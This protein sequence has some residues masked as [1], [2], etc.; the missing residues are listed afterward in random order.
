MSIIHITGSGYTG[1]ND[2]DNWA[3]EY[4]SR[5]LNL[6]KELDILDHP[7]GSVTKQKLSS[8]LQRDIDNTADTADTALD[9]AGDNESA[10]KELKSRLTADEQSTADEHRRIYATIGGLQGLSTADKSDVVSAINEVYSNADNAQTTAEGAQTAADNAQD[11]ADGAQTA[12]DSLTMRYEVTDSIAKSAY[13]SAQE[14]VTKADK[15]QQTAEKTQTEA[16]RLKYY[17]DIDIIPTDSS[18]FT[19]TVDDSGNATIT[20]YTGSDTDVVIPYEIEGNEVVCIGFAAFSVS[21][22][23]L[24]SVVI[25]KSITTIGERAFNA[26]KFT[27]ITIPDSVTTIDKYA[28][29]HCDNL[30]SLIIPDSVTSLGKGICSTC[31]K[32]TSVTFPNS[33]TGITGFS[34]HGESFVV[35]NHI[36]WIDVYGL[37]GSTFTNITIPNS[38]TRIGDHAFYGCSN[39]TNI[40][41]PDSVTS[42]NDMTFCYCSSLTNITIPSAVTSISKTAFINSSSNLTIKCEKNSYAEQYAIDNNIAYEY[43]DNESIDHVHI[44]KNT[45]NEIT[46]E[47]VAEWNGL[48]EYL[49]SLAEISGDYVIEPVVEGVTEKFTLTSSWTMLK[50]STTFLTKEISL[51]VKYRLFAGDTPLTDNIIDDSEPT[52]TAVGGFEG[53]NISIVVYSNTTELFRAKLKTVSIGTKKVGR[54]VRI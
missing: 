17:G 38:V 1:Q 16:E 45:L 41:I 29:S 19:Y 10:I 51:D 24:T 21:G 20:K 42:I 27:N 31:S 8:T 40:T 28:F 50:Y 32:L 48:K 53:D 9:L 52:V 25:P 6:H 14:A 47:K 34:L 22:L 4:L 7:D 18:Y 30:T 39:L 26:G 36:T 13:N 11:T 37:A 12:V 49:E 2:Q 15:A 44:N 23:Q 54:L 35:P 43:Y 46:A 33:I 3:A 5:N